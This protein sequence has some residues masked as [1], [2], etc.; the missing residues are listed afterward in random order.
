MIQIKQYN[1]LQS[2]NVADT[3]GWITQYFSQPS[4]L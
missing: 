4:P 2:K 1:N 3:I